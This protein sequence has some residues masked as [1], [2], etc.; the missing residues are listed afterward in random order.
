VFQTR[1]MLTLCLVCMLSS[2]CS[3]LYEHCLGTSQYVSVDFDKSVLQTDL[4]QLFQSLSEE[5]NYPVYRGFG[6]GE[7]AANLNFGSPDA[8]IT[9]RWSRMVPAGIFR[10]KLHMGVAVSWRHNAEHIQKMSY[11]FQV[12]S[13]DPPTDAQIIEMRR[14][15]DALRG[16]FPQSKFSEKMRGQYLL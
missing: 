4:A 6:F 10:K 11:L 5:L 14:W 1:M 15:E 9:H 7:D 3:P 16:A 8:D 12:P 13:C 2:A